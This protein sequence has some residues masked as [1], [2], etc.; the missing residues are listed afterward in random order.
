[1][2]RLTPNTIVDPAE[3][4]AE[5]EQVR[6]DGYAV[7]DEE[8]ALGVRTL[9]VPILDAAAHARYALAIRATPELITT[10]RLDE[11]RALTQACAQALAAHLLPGMR[12]TIPRRI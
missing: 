8:S 5:L 10:R 12:P 9:A 1:M 4:A 2:Q 3:L 7:N 11:F 6:E